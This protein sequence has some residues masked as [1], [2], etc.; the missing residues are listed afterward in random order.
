MHCEDCGKGNRDGA[1]FCAGC[2]NPLTNAAKAH[3]ETMQAGPK[4]KNVP[5]T[6]LGV[7]SIILAALLTLSLLGVLSG[8]GINKTGYY[9]D[10]LGRLPDESEL[11]PGLLYFYYRTGV[12][13]YVYLTGSI[14]GSSEAPALADMQAFAESKYT[15]LFTDEAH[16]LL[17]LFENDYS[18]RYWF[19]VGKKA[20][21][22]VDQ[23]AGNILG[24]CIDKYYT[25]MNLSYEQFFSNVF[26]DTAD[27]ISITVQAD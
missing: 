6:A 27:S 11:L 22:V 13:P 24:S 21:S 15:E 19:T 9:T 25:D 8:P 12:Q 23:E 1:A 4:K 7:L 20:K 14:N 18:Y 10:E 26:I 5:A 2:G 3:I 16:L 17:V